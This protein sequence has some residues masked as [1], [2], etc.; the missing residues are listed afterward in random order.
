MNFYEQ[1]LKSMFPELDTKSGDTVFAGKAMLS[2]ISDDLRAKVE[3]VTGRVAGQYE[4]LRLSIIN[5]NE[6]VIDSQS[7]MFHEII[8][9]KGSA[10]DRKPHVWDDNGKADWFGYTPTEAELTKI[11]AKVEDYIWMYADQDLGMHM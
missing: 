11:G 6:G 1:Q 10:R 3:F 4:G 9:M 2:V 5:K 8:G 7:F